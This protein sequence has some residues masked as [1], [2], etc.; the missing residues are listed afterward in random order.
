[1]LANLLLGAWA[2]VSAVQLLFLLDRLVAD[3]TTERVAD[4]DDRTWEIYLDTLSN[5]I[6]GTLYAQVGGQWLQVHGIET[7]LIG[8]REIVI[9]TC[10]KNGER[11][12]EVFVY[13]SKLYA[14]NARDFVEPSLI[15][16]VV[17][18]TL[19]RRVY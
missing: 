7:A 3:R 19:S 13:G 5:R 12:I 17:E 14:V 8:G 11:D 9:Y 4:A 15:T 10:G 18:I 1:M 16:E 6:V 2:A